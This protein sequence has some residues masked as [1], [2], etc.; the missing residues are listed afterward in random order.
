MTYTNKDRQRF[1]DIIKANN[2][3][4][5]HTLPVDWRLQMS[6]NKEVNQNYETIFNNY[7]T[8][9]KNVFYD[10]DVYFNK[11]INLLGDV[12]LDDL[13]ININLDD[14]NFSKSILKVEASTPYT[15]GTPTDLEKIDA[16][17]L[18]SK[19]ILYIYNN[20]FYNWGSDITYNGVTYQK[21]YIILDKTDI[22]TNTNGEGTFIFIKNVS[23]SDKYFINDNLE[24]IEVGNGVSL[25]CVIKYDSEDDEYYLDVFMRSMNT[26]Y[27]TFDLI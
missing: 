2:D 27:D 15:T 23:G 19:Q 12:N 9:K 16:L 4:I 21:D 20:D 10:E 7:V 24:V 13:G 5:N 8:F 1:L 26:V 6:S 3:K 25:M 17:T 22:E 18:K 11:G 14:L